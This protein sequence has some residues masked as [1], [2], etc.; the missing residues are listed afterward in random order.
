MKLKRR[1]AVEVPPNIKSFIDCVTATPLENVES[2]LKDFVWEFGKQHLSSLL[3]STDADIVEGSLETLR[4]FVNK[5]V[6][7]SS[8]RS[9]SL[10]SKLFAFSQGWGGKEGGLGLIACSLPSGCDPIATE[11]GS[12]LHFEFYRGADKSDKSQSIDN[13]HRLEII[14]LPSIISCKENDL[15]ILEKLVKDYSVPPSLRFSLLTRLRFARAFD[16]LA[17]RR[18]YTCIR[19]S[20]FIVLLQASHDS[21]S[22]ALFLNNEPEFIDELLSLL[23]YEDEIPEKIRRLGILS[24][25]ALCQDRSHQPTVLS[26]VTSGGH[27]GIL[28]SLM[29][30]AVD[31]IINGSTKWSTEFAE[32][33]LSLVSMLVSSTPGSLAL[34]EAGFIP[35]ILPLL[36]D[37]DTH[38]LHLVSTAVHV[39]EG[40]LDYHNPSSALFRDLGGLDDTIARLKIEVSQVDIGSKKSEEPQS[41]S[42]VCLR[43]I[44]RLFIL[45]R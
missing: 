34:Q 25:V 28:P 23:S 1:R 13:C 2:P 38:H 5:S 24:L 14:H 10:T 9:A 32:E 19:L 41:M 37:T 22:L 39:I 12:T 35:T 15:E 27:R 40:F 3:A 45:K 44:C 8:I 33:L 42:K 29:Q 11:I 16:S 21:E 36:K 7:K 31:S 18:Q 30:K 4:A 43:Q 6:G 26:S 17:Y 20:A